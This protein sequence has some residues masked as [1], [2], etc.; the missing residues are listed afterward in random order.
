M[1]TALS[2]DEVKEILYHAMHNL[3]RK[4]MTEQDYNYLDKSIQEMSGFFETRVENLETPAPPTAVR[5]LTRKMKNSMKWKA[6]SFEDSDED[7]S[8]DKKPSNRKKFY[9]HNGKC[10][11]STDECTTLKA[12]NKKAKSN[13]VKGFRKGGEKTYTKHEINIRIEKK[14]KK[15]FKGR[16]KRKQELRTFEKMKV[17]GSEEND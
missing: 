1:A 11:R 2:D 13:K 15:A 7:S 10:S 3:W 8:D 9:L 12:L 14:R 5:S 16:K 17:S 4:K 6:V